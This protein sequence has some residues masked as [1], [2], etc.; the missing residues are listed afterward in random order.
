MAFSGTK[1]NFPMT[2]STINTTI[3]IPEDWD[4]DLYSDSGSEKGE[5]LFTHLYDK[6]LA[7]LPAVTEV[8]QVPKSSNGGSTQFVGSREGALMSMRSPE[9]VEVDSRGPG[10]LGLA[11]L[12]ADDIMAVDGDSQKNMRSPSRSISHGSL[13]EPTKAPPPPLLILPLPHTS[14][15]EPEFKEEVDSAERTFNTYMGSGGLMV[16]TAPSVEGTFRVNLRR[17]QTGCDVNLRVNQ[18]AIASTVWKTKEEEDS[19]QHLNFLDQCR[20]GLEAE[21][22]N[23]ERKYAQE[24]FSL[25][26]ALHS[27]NPET[28]VQRF[29]RWLESAAEWHVQQKLDAERD[30]GLTFGTAT[31]PAVDPVDAAYDEAFWW[32]CAKQIPKA[33]Q[34]IR[35]IP[36]LQSP[37][38]MMIMAAL[39]GSVQKGSERLCFLSDQINQWQNQKTQELMPPG[40]WRIFALLSGMDRTT[41]TEGCTGWQLGLGA[42]IWYRTSNGDGYC[43]IETALAAYEETLNSLPHNEAS[44]C[45]PRATRKTESGKLLPC[46]DLRYGLI[47]EFCLGPDALEDIVVGVDT[48]TYSTEKMDCWLAWSVVLFLSHVRESSDELQRH[49]AKLTLE[50]VG[51]FELHGEWESALRVAH[52]LA[53]ESLRQ[54]TVMSI[55]ASC[56]DSEKACELVPSRW[57]WEAVGLRSAYERDFIQAA[58]AWLNCGYYAKCIETL[59]DH[60]LLPIVLSCGYEQDRDFIAGPIT[61]SSLAMLQWIYGLVKQM[62]DDGHRD[63]L[64]NDLKEFLESLMTSTASH[65]VK[66]EPE[67]LSSLISESA[68]GNL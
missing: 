59:R 7:P 56:D 43:E 12:I 20:E 29:S 6:P 21:Y 41:V 60:L 32:L 65:P 54:R 50:L 3:M 45:R 49:L 16:T 18:V 2:V 46:D 64:L 34:V 61:G 52:F 31:T 11:N 19:R 17:L 4:L 51:E 55:L 26:S 14:N 44:I 53:D 37:R 13:Q 25:L 15:S 48:P 24:V 67:F 57:V 10:T 22:K 30:A 68:M 39:G 40:L 66:I 62:Y 63:A 58:Q 5:D 27:G 47:R 8:H 9:R 28:S 1:G 38:L 42:H 36:G 23:E 33:I 35:R